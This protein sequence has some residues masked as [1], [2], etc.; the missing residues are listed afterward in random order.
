MKNFKSSKSLKSAVSLAVVG[1]LFMAY[2]CGNS[3]EQNTL[4]SSNNSIS[5]QNTTTTTTT[6][7]E[8]T[9]TLLETTTTTL[10][11]VTTTTT[12]PETT[13]TTTLPVVTTT[14]SAVP[15]EAEESFENFIRAV[16]TER[17]RELEGIK[18]KGIEILT[19]K[20]PDGSP[21]VNVIILRLSENTITEEYQNTEYLNLAYAS[22]SIAPFIFSFSCTPAKSSIMGN[23]LIETLETS[24]CANTYWK[25]ILRTSC[26]VG[27]IITINC[28]TKSD[29]SVTM[30]IVA[31]TKQ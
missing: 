17:L 13:T 22:R 5:E 11:E 7:Q 1:V 20:N 4:V 14:T 30:T 8:T 9:T 28:Q 31:S 12:L 24:K 26:V 10:P 18:A 27:K 15:D 25:G 19:A 23:F 3:G 6:K 16:P 29:G 2:A 21:S